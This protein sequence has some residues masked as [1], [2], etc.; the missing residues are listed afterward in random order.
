MTSMGV[1][2][3]I[4]RPKGEKVIS[5]RWVDVNKKDD[6]NPK[7]RSRLVARE[8]KKKYA[9]KVSD[10]AH[11]PSWEDFYASMPP[12]SALRTLFALAT[13]NRAPGLDGRMR[14]LPRNRCLVFLDIKKAHFW[15]DARRRI[16]VE[17]PMETGVDT[18]KYVGLLKKSLYG[19]RDAPANWEA[20]ILR[21][22]T[23][24]GFVQGRSNSCLYFHPGRQ[25]QVEVHGDDFTGLGSKDHLEWFATELG[26]HWTIEV[27]GYLGPP[28]MAGTQQTTDIL[29]R[30]V[31]WSAKG[32]ELEADP[33][34]A[35]IIMNEMGCAGAKVSSALVTR[36]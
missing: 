23:L 25:I 16:L 11:T 3:I 14:E 33:R 21:V 26:K 19:T 30:L 15:A 18:E 6:R 29:N 9:G 8:L 36:T 2:E 28:G 17:L 10:E 27:R 13:T 20:T 31:T 5:T 32:I 22:M 1:W 34:H 35:E 7:Y 12:I 24:L 4:P